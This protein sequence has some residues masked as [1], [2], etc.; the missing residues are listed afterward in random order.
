MKL[1]SAAGLVVWIV[2]AAGAQTE[3]RP[4][5][6][7]AY[8]IWNRITGQ[9]ISDDG[10]WVLYTIRAGDPEGEGT[11]VV[12]R[13]ES[14]QSFSAA[15]GTSAS[16]SECNGFVAYLVDPDPKVVEQEKKDKVPADKQSKKAL[17][18]LNLSTG[19]TMRVERVRS[20]SMPTEAGGLIAYHL[21]KP[22]PPEKEEEKAGEAKPEAKPEE[23]SAQA[24]APE[25]EQPP[26][27]PEQPPA[28]EQPEQAEAPKK[29]EKKKDPGTELVLRALES[30]EERRF[31][32]VTAYEF[33][34]DGTLLALA[35]SSEDAGKDGVLVVETAT[36]EVSRIASGRGHYKSLAFDEG[37]TRLAFLTDRDDYESDEP[38][39]SVMVWER[40]AEHA[41][42]A[43]SADSDGIPDGWWVSDRQGPSFSKSG[44][45]LFI[46]TAPRPA[47]KPEEA[48][49]DESDE[50]KITLDIWHWRDPQL[51]PQQ[52]RNASREKNRTYRAVVHRDGAIV[53]IETPEHQSVTVG[54]DGDAEVGICNDD[55]PYRLRDS[56][57]SPGFHDVYL[58]DVRTGERER[59]LT[60]LRGSASLSPAA[61]YVTWWDYD[62]R[63][64]RA[65]S[66][67]TRETMNLTGGIGVPFH[68]EL[69]DMPAPPRP[70]GVAGWTE[71]DGAVLIYDRFDVW[72]VDPS[73]FWPPRCVTE[74]YGRAHEIRLRVMRLDR[75]EEWIDADAPLHLSAFH[76]RTKASGAYR[77]RV[78]G[79][80]EPVRLV[81]LD[82]QLGV[83]RKADDAD[84]L[85][86]T[87]ETFREFGDLWVSGLDFADARRLTDANPQQAEYRWGDAEIVE[88]TSLDGER[89]QGILY[90]PDGFD[91]S[92]QYP[93]LVYFYERSSDGLHSYHAPAPSSSSINRS[94][95]V[96]RGYLV[97]VPDIP[98]KVGRPGQSCLSAV[99]PGIASLVDA[100]F[101]DKRRIG[102]QGH[103]WGGYQIAYLVTRT[104]IFRAAE[105][106]APVSN[107]TSAYGGIRWGTGVSRMFQYED[108]QS[109]I[110]GTLWEAQPLYLENSPIFM[111]DRIGTPL[112]I[113]HND[114]DGAVPWY[115]GIELF[116]ALRRLGKPCWMFN[117]N[118]EDH[119]LRQR[120]NQKDWAVRMQQF[121]D[122]YLMDAPP[123]VW[124]AE[125][126]PAVEK[127]ENL[128]LD[129]IESWTSDRPRVGEDRR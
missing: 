20:F 2:M 91:P 102:V 17:A 118:G 56:W 124:L 88:W 115:Q 10:R 60:E 99:V 29:K 43:A 68:D 36:G 51:Q 105:A 52:L 123:P 19:E 42:V 128:G 22:L 70:H 96:S 103:S 54:A 45:R 63:Q 78:R 119:G 46:A 110:G 62:S 127:G 6:H 69:N 31:A 37:A 65:M 113:L 4:L 49:E 24:P 106:G 3:K 95:Y 108:A 97:F 83:P 47:P 53:Q 39:W 1:A 5:D 109:R 77:D 48:E 18:I 61:K 16:F 74:G 30:G 64:W 72:A 67:R 58:V 87:R 94:F 33:S 40:G 55:R 23:P 98:Y 93:M 85:L 9:Q 84:V 125:G 100:G 117:Y 89:L 8:D 129:L 112:L 25:P 114:Q 92:K 73:G 111:A 35:I 32:D 57:E 80:A 59:I 101:V 66:V 107:M 27:Q 116:V 79:D 7:D 14:E 28:G 71:G 86:Y 50:P 122:H 126:V 121:F 120:H 13:V 21:E 82:A 12:R 90:K 44:E 15:R 26:A 41:T 81:M 38:A 76:V 11:L 75:E 34:R 104:D